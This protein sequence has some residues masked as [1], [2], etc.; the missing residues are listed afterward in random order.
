ME[1]AR[2]RLEKT[3]GCRKGEDGVIRKQEKV[4]ARLVLRG[5]A[6]SSKREATDS[7]VDSNAIFRGKCHID[8]R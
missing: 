1:P 4:M 3:R 7:A 5:D 6:L 2:R 8:D